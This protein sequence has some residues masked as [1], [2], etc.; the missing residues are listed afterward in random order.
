MTS[1]WSTSKKALVHLRKA[2][3]HYDVLLSESDDE[4]WAATV[5]CTDGTI[6][7][8]DG[9]GFELDGSTRVNYEDIST[10]YFK[11][12]PDIKD[13]A[14]KK[15]SVKLG[16]EIDSDWALYKGLYYESLTI[17]INNGKV[18]KVNDQFKYSMQKLIWFIKS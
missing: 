3:K 10:C 14:E 5:R 2:Q 18:I 8:F 1:N 4:T 15:F 17:E 12:N 7:N 11:K 9:F 16:F 13:W 6:W